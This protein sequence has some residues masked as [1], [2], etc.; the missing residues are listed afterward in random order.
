MQITMTAKVSMTQNLQSLFDECQKTEKYTESLGFVLKAMEQSL[1][2][3]GV[4]NEPQHDKTNKMTCPAK[5]QINPGICPVFA[6]HL[7]KVGFLTTHKALSEDSGQSG[8][9]PGLI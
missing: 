4:L 8:R 5:T 7:K 6:A 2:F 1:V 9:M 3:C